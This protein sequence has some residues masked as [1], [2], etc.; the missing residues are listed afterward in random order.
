V[1]AAQILLPE[2]SRCPRTGLGAAIGAIA[3]NAGMRAAKG[4]TVGAV[5]SVA[6]KGKEVKVPTETLIEFRLEQSA[7]LPAQ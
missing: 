5:G 1:A 2:S 3:G 7:Y 4:A 6:Q